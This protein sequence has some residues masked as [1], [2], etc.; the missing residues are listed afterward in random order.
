[1]RIETSLMKAW[2]EA[3]GVTANAV[4]HTNR[5]FT[6]GSQQAK[7]IRDPHPA[8]GHPL[9]IRQPLLKLLSLG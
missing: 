4:E 8:F 6:S 1:M 2:A 9:Q 5:S 7:G 3:D